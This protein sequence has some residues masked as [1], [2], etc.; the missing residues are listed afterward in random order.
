VSLVSAQ[1][2][3]GWR[4]EVKDPGPT[5]VRVELESADERSEVRVEAACRAGQPAFTVDQK[6]E[7]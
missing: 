2:S 1:P 6:D 5:R 7:D 3:S 4:V